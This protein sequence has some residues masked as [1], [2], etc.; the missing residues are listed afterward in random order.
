[1]LGEPVTYRNLTVWPVF[2]EEPAE[3]GEFLTL[4]EAL[5]Q[6]VAEVSE[7]KG[8]GE[9]GSLVI[10]NAADVPILICAGTVV[11]GGK[12]DR[13]IGQDFVVQAK[14]TTP[15]DTF[16]VEQGRWVASRGGQATEDKFD[17]ADV[18]ANAAIRIKGQYED[19]QHEVWK[20]VDVVKEETIAACEIEEE[21]E[22]EEC[23]E[24]TSLAVL[25]EVNDEKMA[26]YGNSIKAHF[27]AARRNDLGPS[28]FAYAV[29]GRPVSVRTFAH[30]EIFRRQFAPL[31]KGMAVEALLGQG[32]GPTRPARAADVLALVRETSGS[33]EEVKETTALN[34]NGI[35]TAKKAFSS[36]CYVPVAGHWIAITSDWTARR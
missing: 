33:S 12:Q 23:E 11:K 29:N 35:R 3:I 28:G 30:E 15:V 18:T 14:M 17:A 24:T 27:A 1:V 22:I 21:E 16:C 31:W 32:E 25:L 6:G 9:V 36:A 13:Q 2:N 8:G 7:R 34:R 4:H 20:G 19:D 10:K 26:G 5:D